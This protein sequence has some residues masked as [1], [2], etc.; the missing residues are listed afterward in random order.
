MT[1]QS[2]RPRRRRT[3]SAKPKKPYA[4]FPLTP[5]ASGAWQKKIRGKIHYFGKWAKRVDG[6][7]E[8]LPG[9]GWQ[10]ALAIYKAQ[11]DDLHAGRKPRQKNEDLTIADL[12]NHFLTDKQRRVDSAEMSGRMFHEYKATTD[13]LVKAF[14]KS[15]LVADLAGEDFSTLRASLA[16]QFGPVRLG[17]EVQKVRTVFKYA[18]PSALESHESQVRTL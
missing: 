5:H 6:K 8:R 14:G 4:E 15:R 12:C 9:D 13:R 1:V 3:Q 11:A 10:E 7:L 2:N 17:N 16:K 18:L